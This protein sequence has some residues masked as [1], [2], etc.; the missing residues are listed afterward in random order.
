VI[1]EEPL[2]T[3]SVYASPPLLTDRCSYILSTFECPN[4]AEV[5]LLTV[6]VAL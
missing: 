4:Q 6:E 5:H 1:R 2:R 3:I